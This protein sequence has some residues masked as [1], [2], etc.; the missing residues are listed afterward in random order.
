MCVK[1]RVFIGQSEC[2]TPLQVTTVCVKCLHM[3]QQVS[4]IFTGDHRVRQTSLQVRV[5]VKHRVFI[6]Q[7]GCQIPL[8]VTTACV[9]LLYRSECV[10]NIE[11]L[12]VRVGVKHLYRWLKS[13]LNVFTGQG[14][15][16]TPLQVTTECVKRQY[17]SERVSNTYTGDHSVCQT[18]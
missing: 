15:C 11:S 6:G 3:S 12:P 14:G 7:S 13:V 2:Q 17:R 4:N 8:Q 1:H 18:S 16:Q 5:C 10:S 9:K